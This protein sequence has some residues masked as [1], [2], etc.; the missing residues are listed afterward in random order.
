[1]KRIL[2]KRIL[3]VL[4]IAAVTA[5]ITTPPIAARTAEPFRMPSV[6]TLDVEDEAEKIA[7]SA[8][9]IVGWLL[10]NNDKDNSEKQDTASQM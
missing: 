8:A 3:F 6:P 5:L 2:L 9:Q 1:V 4:A 7:D 10:G